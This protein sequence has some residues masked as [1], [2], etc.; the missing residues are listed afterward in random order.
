LQQRHGEPFGSADAAT[1]EA[2]AIAAAVAAAIGLPAVPAV[3][4]PTAAGQQDSRSAA[5]GRSTWASRARA[6]ALRG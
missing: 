4:G 3:T 5:D 6:E 2:A 1:E